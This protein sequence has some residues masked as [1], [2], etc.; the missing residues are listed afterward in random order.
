MSQLSVIAN[1]RKMGSVEFLRN[2]LTFRYDEDWRN[3]AAGFPLSVSMPL[4][5]REHPH[6]VIESYLWGLL[7]DNRLVIEQWGRK[8]QVSP[9]NVFR[10]IEQVGE[11]CAGAV[12]FIPEEREATLLDRAES[13]DL[14]WIS[15]GELAAR[16][17][18]L[19]R[20]DAS[21]RNPRDWSQ[22]QDPPGT[23]L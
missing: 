5:R 13:D 14:T 15:S 10:L 2:R 20:D 8:F 16:I 1:S 3:T 19:V 6:D 9:N 7:P 21:T 4:S 18:E 11:D 23:P 22:P 17:R 12:Q